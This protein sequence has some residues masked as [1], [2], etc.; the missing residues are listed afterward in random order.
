MGFDLLGQ[1]SHSLRLGKGLSAAEGNSSK[2]G[3]FS[4]SSTSW[5]ISTSWPPLKVVGLRV[6]TAGAVVGT[7]LGKDHK[8]QTR[9]VHNRLPDDA[10]NADLRLLVLCQLDSLFLYLIPGSRSVAAKGRKSEAVVNASFCNSPAFT[11]LPFFSRR[12]APFSIPSCG[13]LPA[14]SLTT[15]SI[16]GLLSRLCFDPVMLFG[17]LGVVEVVQCALQIAGDPADP[18]KAH[19]FAHHTVCRYLIDLFHNHL[20]LSE[21]V[22]NTPRPFPFRRIVGGVFL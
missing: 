18:L 6:V 7:P 9:P 8:P 20:F 14:A 1:G 2:Q 4:I 16:S 17:P 10:C 21:T 13:Q 3:F 22:K 11:I 19:A 5:E 15:F 12:S